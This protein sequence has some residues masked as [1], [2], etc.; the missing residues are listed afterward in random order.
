MGVVGAAHVN[1]LLGA[2]ITI[3]VTVVT[4]RVMERSLDQIDAE[5][6]VAGLE[7]C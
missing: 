6:K 5:L 3:G 7:S 4:T 1:L 2:I